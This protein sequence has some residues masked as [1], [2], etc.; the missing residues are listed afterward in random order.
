MYSI[1]LLVNKIDVRYIDPRGKEIIERVKSD[2]LWVIATGN[3]IYTFLHILNDLYSEH[4]LLL[5]SPLL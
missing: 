4:V 2:D 3:F 1:I 5:K